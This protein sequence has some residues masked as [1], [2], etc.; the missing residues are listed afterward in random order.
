[1]LIYKSVPLTLMTMYSRENYMLS[2]RNT[3]LEKLKEVQLNSL[4]PG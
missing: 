2:V 1:M 4:R 3:V